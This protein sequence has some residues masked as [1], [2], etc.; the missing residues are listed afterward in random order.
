MDENI[1]YGVIWM[2]AMLFTKV[3]ATE[4]LVCCRNETK[5]MG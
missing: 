2:A 3:S 1:L 4:N 5:V